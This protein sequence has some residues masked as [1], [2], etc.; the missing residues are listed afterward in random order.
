MIKKSHILVL[1]LTALT[2][3][4][5][6]SAKEQL[7]LNRSAPDE[8]MVVKRAPLSMP[9]DYTLSPPRPGAP[10]PQEQA[11]S[12]MARDALFGDATGEAV[13]V[14]DTSGESTFLQ[15]AGAEYANPEIRSI[16]D[17]ETQ[18]LQESSKSVAKKLI[19]IG[20]DDPEGEVLDPKAEADRLQ[21]VNAAPGDAYEEATE[22]AVTPE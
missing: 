10:R 22:P 8:F 3:G 5:C 15:E 6:S 14:T 21:G 11:T 9:P 7:G 4:A 1:S 13:P 16:V 19:G 12:T 2:L 17:I 20:A 18:E